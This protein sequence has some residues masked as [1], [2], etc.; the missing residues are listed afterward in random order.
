MIEQLMIDKLMSVL[1]NQLSHLITNKC[2][3]KSQLLQTS[4][5][6]SA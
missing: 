1:V 4:V 3:F 2:V 6:F 5:S